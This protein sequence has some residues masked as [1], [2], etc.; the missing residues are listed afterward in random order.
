VDTSNFPTADRETLERVHKWRA[1][2]VVLVILDK[3]EKLW[4]LLGIML[5]KTAL[6]PLVF[7]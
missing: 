6:E 1:L 2:Y 5:L 7:S 4:H 3:P